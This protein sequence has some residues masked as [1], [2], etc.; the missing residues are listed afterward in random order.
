M[1]KI[2]AMEVVVI[3][4]VVLIIT[5]LLW[6]NWQVMARLFFTRTM[7]GGTI[8]DGYFYDGMPFEDDGY[9]IHINLVEDLTNPLHSSQSQAFHRITE[10]P[11]KY[12]GEYIRFPRYIRY[13]AEGHATVSTESII[14]WVDNAMNPVALTE[15]DRKYTTDVEQ[16]FGYII[17]LKYCDKLEEYITDTERDRYH[18]IHEY[19]IN[20]YSEYAQPFADLISRDLIHNIIDV[21]GMTEPDEYMELDSESEDSLLS[22]I[23]IKKQMFKC[24]PEP[25]GIF[26]WNKSVHSGNIW[27]AYKVYTD[28]YVQELYGEDVHIVENPH[29]RQHEF[30]DWILPIKIYLRREVETGWLTTITR[31]SEDQLNANAD[32]ERAFK[33]IMEKTSILVERDQIPFLKFILTCNVLTKI[34]SISVYKW[35]LDA[36]NMVVDKSTTES[37]EFVYSCYLVIIRYYKAFIRLVSKKIEHS[38]YGY[39]SKY[40]NKINAYA[41]HMH[42]VLDNMQIGYDLIKKQFGPNIDKFSTVYTSSIVR[43][44]E[45]HTN[46]TMPTLFKTIDSEQLRKDIMKKLQVNAQRTGKFAIILNKLNIGTKKTTQFNAIEEQQLSELNELKGSPFDKLPEDKFGIEPDLPVIKFSNR[47]E[48]QRERLKYSFQPALCK[49]AVEYE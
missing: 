23:L 42:S 15:N 45:K 40:I 34:N 44:F 12:N 1:E 49:V 36:F 46:K 47:K 29:F 10:T 19:V 9:H 4:I 6:A 35:A 14:E 2:G 32:R 31:L 37:P 21:I 17:V 43:L 16:A 26:N 18:H 28:A 20:K 25:S 48:Q 7:V 3:V 24:R 5:C 38:V 39:P 22:T 8:E 13:I 33:F 41:N 27:K 30:L 11:I